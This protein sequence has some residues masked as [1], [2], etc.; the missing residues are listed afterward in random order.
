MARTLLGCLGR[1]SFPALS[2]AAPHIL[3]RQ[4]CD[5]AS[6]TPGLPI[7]SAEQADDVARR[8]SRDSPSLFLV[9]HSPTQPSRPTSPCSSPPPSSRSPSC[10]RLPRPPRSP[11]TRAT[12]RASPRPPSWAS[13]PSCSARSSASRSP[14]PRPSTVPVPLA[15]FQFLKQ[16]LTQLENFLPL[17][18]GPAG[19]RMGAARPFRAVTFC[20]QSHSS[21]SLPRGA[22]YLLPGPCGSRPWDCFFV[23]G[24]DASAGAPAPRSGRAHRAGRPSAR[25]RPGR[26]AFTQRGPE[27]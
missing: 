19:T 24:G 22:C 15:S 3:A 17:L 14:A 2:S 20:S 8:G 21:Q 7:L 23:C 25:A 13:R 27:E 9:P 18:G 1:F 11:W 12:G 26:A 5:R 4:Q 16:P 10:P 6:D